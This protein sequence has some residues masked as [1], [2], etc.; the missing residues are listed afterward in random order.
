MKTLAR[1]GLL[2]LAAAML[3]LT[4]CQ[5][6]KKGNPYAQ[7]QGSTAS[8]NPYGSSYGSYGTP[9][10]GGGYPNAND[11]VE[12]Q[13]VGSGGG[14]AQQPQA[15]YGSSDAY[16]QGGYGGG[17]SQQPAPYVPPAPAP[18][19]V[20]EQPYQPPYTPAP[21]TTTPVNGYQGTYTVQKGDTLYSIGRRH[22]TTAE[23][24]KAVN[25]L[26]S[27]L[28]FPGDVLNIP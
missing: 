24:I 28:I 8:Q 9:A 20:N 4:S 6:N 2:I 15:P 23:Q 17:Y 25:G 12:V 13:P 1:L 27:N 14:Y 10:A 5:S 21:H 11:Y 7:Q 18:P 3:T 19:V 16:G 22:N 26:D